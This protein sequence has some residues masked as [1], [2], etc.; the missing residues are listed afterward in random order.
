MQVPNEVP[1]RG[2]PEVLLS[3]IGIAFHYRVDFLRWFRLQDKAKQAEAPSRPSYRY[4]AARLLVSG[5]APA[6]LR[7]K[8]D[9]R[10]RQRP[11]GPGTIE[12]KMGL[13]RERWTDK[14][15]SFRN[16]AHNLAAGRPLDDLESSWCVHGI[17][18]AFLL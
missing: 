9:N 16:L 11:R 3:S 6:S 2:T 15:G 17:V 18:A 1:E 12:G 8:A 10:R 7:F 5:L 13:I 4:S 14:V